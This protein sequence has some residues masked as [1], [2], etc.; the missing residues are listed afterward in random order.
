MDMAADSAAQEE[1]RLDGEQDQAQLLGDSS[2][3]LEYAEAELYG[4]EPP[5]GATATGRSFPLDV[6]RK[7]WLWKLTIG[8]VL[9]VGYAG[10]YVCRSNLSVA[11]PSLI[12]DLDLSKSTF[13]IVLTAGT[14][15][16]AVGKFVTGP[17]IDSMGG[18][19]VFLLA[20]LC[21]ILL[22]VV[23]TFGS[24]VWYFTL[25][26]IGN[27]LVQAAGWPAVVKIT[28]SWYHPSESGKAMGFISLSF[29]FGDAIARFYL[30]GVLEATDDSW[31]AVFWV[32]AITLGAIGVLCFFLLKG[33]P[34]DVG[35]PLED[36]KHTAKQSTADDIDETDGR[37]QVVGTESQPGSWKERI[38]P[39]LRNPRFWLLCFM[40]FG[41]TLL[42]STFTDWANVYLTDETHASPSE[43]ALGSIMFPLSGGFSCLLV[44]WLNDKLSRGR[45]GLML[46]GFLTVLAI[47][48]GAYSLLSSRSLPLALV[49]VTLVGFTLTGPYTLP[50]GALSLSIGGP[51]CATVSALVDTTGY[52][53]G[54]LSGYLVGLL[55]ETYGWSTVWGLLAVVTVATIFVTAAF[56]LLD[57]RHSLPESLPH[58][59]SSSDEYELQETGVDQDDGELTFHLAEDK[60]K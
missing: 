56:S 35:L 25:V 14:A 17:V 30:A 12:K 38:G 5:L 33:S 27:R 13:G 54:L 11:S 42:R 36:E 10:Y 34:A 15:A 51:M 31:V 59:N 19:K 1:L 24:A 46:M 7:R 9:I 41:L 47:T 52:I 49:F 3:T 6:A 37:I 53:G 26:W 23:F 8:L 58:I 29:L 4:A 32:S 43:A 40:S 55:A 18:R 60:A 44:G 16:Y 39:L 28:S 21:S 22:T 20:M 50:A 48:L 57:Y 2:E 45:R